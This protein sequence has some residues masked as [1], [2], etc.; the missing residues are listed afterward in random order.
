MRLLNKDDNIINTEHKINIRNI[1]KIFKN[2][3]KLDLRMN[4]IDDINILENVNFKK[5]K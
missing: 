2:L 5:L 3:E 4:K 1:L